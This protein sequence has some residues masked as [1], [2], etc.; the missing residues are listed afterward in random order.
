MS[1]GSVGRLLRF[2][3]ILS[4]VA[5]LLLPVSMAFSKR[6]MGW[7]S[8]VAVQGTSTEGEPYVLHVPAPPAVRRAGGRELREF[9]EGRLAVAATGCIACHRIGDQ[10]N[11][12]PGPPLT[13]IGS[14]LTER[15]IR[16]ALMDPRAP[17]PSFR[18]MGPHKLRVMI[19]FL[20]LLR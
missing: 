18:D 8:D 11:R 16:R 7:R 1:L 6:A 15:E 12:G 13:R 20:S 2:Y 4:V 14:K 3:V 9:K 17:M 5:G 10:G 19:R